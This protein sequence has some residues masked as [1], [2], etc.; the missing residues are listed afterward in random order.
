MDGIKSF[1]TNIS[2]HKIMSMDEDKR[3]R[4]INAALEEFSKGFRKANTDTIVQN[5][6]ISKGL[7]FHYFG[8]KKELFLFLIRYCT[9]IISDEFNSVSFDSRDFLENVWNMSLLSCELT[10]K[11]SL[12][13]KFLVPAI[14]SMKTE[15]PDES[16][17]NYKNPV[18]EILGN[19]FKIF[20]HSLFRDDV[21]IQK[22]CNV[23]LWAIKG[24]SDS[25]MSYGNNLEDYTEHYETIK[26][27]LSEYMVL[28]RKAF[29]K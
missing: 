20:D 10:V 18:A 26:K 8:T 9:D 14:T 11:Y 22:A 6:A 1:N 17:S 5:S 2:A 3:N 29:Y 7:L 4:V 12:V 13:Y 28:L 23:I 25:L 27:E 16:L 15:F 21:D 19:S 24:Y